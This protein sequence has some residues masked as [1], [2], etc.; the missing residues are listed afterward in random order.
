VLIDAFTYFNEK[1]I[2]ELRIRTLE[3]Y[4]DGFL[5]A[6]A[7]RT[8]RGEEKPF[9]CVET[10]KELGISDEKIQVLHVEL[11][12]S[13]EVIDPWVRERGQ[14]DALGVGLQ[15][16]PD[17]TV[18][19]CSDCD[20]IAN[21][22][23]LKALKEV[24]PASDGRPVKL[25][26]SMHY[27]RADRQLITPDGKLHNWRNAFASTVGFLKDSGTLS[28]MRAST[29]NIY[30][31]DLDAGWHF[32][33]MGDSA[34][35][36]NKLK[37]Y[38]HWETDRPDIEKTCERF[39]ADLGSADMLGREDHLITEYPA[40]KLPKGVFDLERVKSFLLP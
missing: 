2:L 21:P 4:V 23:M 15:M 8:H 18:F 30:F 12:S 17:D 13:D 11:P 16:L 26:M 39:N 38:A 27:G 29:D 32:S 3:D 22:E 33:W 7:N 34:R 6:D 5:I 14:R 20:E 19:I 25:S 9:T 1:E 10:L 35:R 31:G 36:L 28:S 24:V 40:D 37:S